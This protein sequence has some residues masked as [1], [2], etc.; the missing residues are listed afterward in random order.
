MSNLATLFRIMLLYCVSYKWHVH[1]ERKRK[2][3]QVRKLKKVDDAGLDSDLCRAFMSQ[4]PDGLDDLSSAGEA[5]GNPFDR[6]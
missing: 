3:I 5:R 1:E 2:I 4:I 6:F